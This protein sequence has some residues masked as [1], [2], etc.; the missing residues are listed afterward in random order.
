MSTRDLWQSYDCP[1]QGVDFDLDGEGLVFYGQRIE[2]SA[3]GGSHVGGEEVSVETCVDFVGEDGVVEYEK[4]K[5]HEL[6][7]TAEELQRLKDAK[8]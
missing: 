1:S 6:P 5:F 2:C 8:E 3:C 4:R 7:K